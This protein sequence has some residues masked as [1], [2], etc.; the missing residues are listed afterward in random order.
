VLQVYKVVVDTAGSLI[1]ADLMSLTF[2][3]ESEAF[4]Y[5]KSYVANV[6]RF[7]RS[8][9]D[10]VEEC[11]WGCD[12]GPELQLYRYRLEMR[13]TAADLSGVPAYTCEGDGVDDCPGAEPSVH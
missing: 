10:E 11:W 4:A 2:E 9:Y 3:N 5:M 12:A 1:A 6:F 8:G 13:C 7:G